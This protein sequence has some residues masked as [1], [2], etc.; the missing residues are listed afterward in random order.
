MALKIVGEF[1]QNPAGS[2]SADLVT[3]KDSFVQPS[4]Y[5]FEY[6]ELLLYQKHD[7]ARE[8]GRLELAFG[9]IGGEQC[10]HIRPSFVPGDTR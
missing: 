1:W 4:D 8:S 5:D 7:S 2:L 10:A 3:T 6:S 9:E